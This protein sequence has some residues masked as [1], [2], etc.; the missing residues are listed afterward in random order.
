[1]MVHITQASAP[2]IR[3]ICIRCIMSYDIVVA[4][5]E[6]AHSFPILYS[7]TFDTPI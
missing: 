3:G 5:N 4:E 6:N 2:S 7:F 1:M